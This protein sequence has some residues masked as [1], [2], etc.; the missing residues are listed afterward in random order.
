MLS[1]DN[2]NMEIIILGW[3]FQEWLQ[4]DLPV[5][6][7]INWQQFSLSNVKLLSYHIFQNPKWC[8]QV[9]CPKK[10]NKT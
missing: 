7:T 9:L 2:C 10:W 6:F 3:Y 5:I 8:Y 1:T 4:T